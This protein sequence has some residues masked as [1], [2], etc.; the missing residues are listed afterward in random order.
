MH[1]LSANYFEE[2]SGAHSLVRFVLAGSDE[3]KLDPSL[4]LKADSLTLK[5]LIRKKKFRILF[6]LLPS[7]NYLLYAVQLENDL[8]APTSIWAIVEKQEELVAISSFFKAMECPF[9][10]FNETN[11]NVCWANVRFQ[12]AQTAMVGRV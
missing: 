7:N 9:S 4:I 11:A 3:L 6:S 5:Y 12:L 2:F 8:L 10:L 1:I